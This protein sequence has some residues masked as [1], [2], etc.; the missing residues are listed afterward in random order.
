M[1]VCSWAISSHCS[2]DSAIR[3]GLHPRNT[4]TQIG[5]KYFG[6]RKC[7]WWICTSVIGLALRQRHWHTQPSAQSCA[8]QKPPSDW[9]AEICSDNDQMR[10]YVLHPQNIDS[11]DITAE[12]VSS[13]GLSNSI[14]HWPGSRCTYY[15]RYLLSV[16]SRRHICCRRSTFVSSYD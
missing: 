12:L 13:A 11:Y 3:T 16:D 10:L 2:S 14:K 4:V 9:S 5:E 6:W 7:S 15:L 8:D 1:N